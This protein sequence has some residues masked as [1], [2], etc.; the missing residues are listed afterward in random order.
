MKKL[1]IVEDEVE[2]LRILA[3]QFDKKDFKVLEAADGEQGL[4]T[5]LREH[6]DLILLDLVMPVMDGMTMLGKL[7]HDSWGKEVK[8]VVLTNL[9]DEHK[10]REALEPGTFDYLI[11][12]NWHINDVVKKVKTKLGML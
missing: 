4:K 10:V 12:A 9:D 7:R 5:A 1:L 8:V 2:L 11:K 3:S 6:P